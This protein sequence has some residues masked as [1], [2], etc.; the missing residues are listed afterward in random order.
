METPLPSEQIISS[1]NSCSHQLCGINGRCLPIINHNS[2]YFCSCR[3]GF[4]G[5]HCQNYDVRC[6]KHCSPN[7]ICKPDYG[8]IITSDRKPY[9]LCPKT[10]YGPTCALK[11]DQCSKNPCKYNGTCHMSYDPTDMQ[12]YTCSCTGLYYGINCELPKA[13][14]TVIIDSTN[15]SLTAIA[16]TIQF[17]DIDSR[18]RTDL[19]L[20][21]QQVFDSVPQKTFLRHD[22]L[23]S[24]AIAILKLYGSD[25][26]TREPTYYLGYVQQNLKDINV[27]NNLE[28]KCSHVQSLWQ[29]FQTNT[30]SE[31]EI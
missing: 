11:N 3:S 29:L 24:P 4:Y 15:S 13:S 19:F 5:K 9:C 22:Q 18:T 17:Y 8:G 31:Y 28:S 10:H 7:S 30:S 26:L 1:N 25:D 2:T 12:N 6:A 20:R 16:T 23:T 14:V 27:T 21:N